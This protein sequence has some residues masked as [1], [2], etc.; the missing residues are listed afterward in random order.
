MVDWRF[1]KDSDT[2]CGPGEA[3]PTRWKGRRPTFILCAVKIFGYIVNH[4]HIIHEAHRIN[5]DDHRVLPN[6]TI[7]DIG[8]STQFE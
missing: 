3:R 8:E 1:G 2:W 6:I 4:G 7:G 5:L